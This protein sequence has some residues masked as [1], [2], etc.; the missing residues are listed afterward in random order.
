MKYWVVIPAAGIGTRMGAEIPKQYLPLAGRTVIECTLER[1]L[2][3]SMISGIT[4]AL[5]ENDCWWQN[6]SYMGNEKIT[7]VTGGEERAHSVLNGLV[8][9]MGYAAPDDWVL[10]HDAA[11]PCVRLEDIS[12]LIRSVEHHPVGGLLGMRI[13]DTM[14][15]TDETGKILQTVEREHLW[16]AFTP[17]MFRLGHL[18]NALSDSLN[19]GVAITDEASAMEWAGYSPL[20]V[21][22]H[23]D[24]IK[25]TQPADLALAE[26]YLGR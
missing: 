10:V 24:N 12:A 14:K 5:A 17:Q 26:Y 3:H 1:L 13:R 2:S 25:I 21:E 9:L 8:D 23:G 18:H 22:G 20:L 6:S 19:A 4:L 15:R 11:R 7:T 16:H